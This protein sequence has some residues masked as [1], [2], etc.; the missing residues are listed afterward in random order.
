MHLQMYTF[1]S[2]SSIIVVHV[3][4]CVTTYFWLHYLIFHY[5]LQCTMYFNF[6]HFRTMDIFVLGPDRFGSWLFWVLIVLGPDRFGSWSFG[7]VHVCTYVA[8]SMMFSRPIKN[9]IW[10][11]CAEQ[12][13]TFY[14]LH[15]YTHRMLTH[16][17][18][19]TEW[20]GEFTSCVR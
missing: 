15:L 6:Y 4:V 20:Q 5:T 1:F 8:W 12:L 14:M 18:T 19:G 3:S 17:S 7:I 9:A 16:L 10:V 2:I 11:C 13:D